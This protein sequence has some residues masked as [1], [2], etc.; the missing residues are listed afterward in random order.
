PRVAVHAATQDGLTPGCGWGDPGARAAD[1]RRREGAVPDTPVTATD[2]PTRS[3]ATG[4]P[5]VSTAGG[6][7]LARLRPRAVPMAPSVAPALD[8]FH[9]GL[10]PATTRNRFFAVHPHLTEAELARFTTVDHVER[11]ALVAIDG[12][13]DVVAVARFDR[14][15]PASPTAEVAFVVADRW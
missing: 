1:G 9:E 4:V 13:G 7:A 6:D 10:S 5:L 14:L 2:A 11:D 12:A 8:R 3:G 15:A